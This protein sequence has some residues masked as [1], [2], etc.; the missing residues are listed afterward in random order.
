MEL[1]LSTPVSHLSSQGMRQK[2]Y[3]VYPPQKYVCKYKNR[4][5][6]ENNVFNLKK[7]LENSLLATVSLPNVKIDVF[8]IPTKLIIQNF[9]T[10]KR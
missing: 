5:I 4:N 9:Q 3:T 8:I 2:S 7:E 10:F 1:D 6:Q